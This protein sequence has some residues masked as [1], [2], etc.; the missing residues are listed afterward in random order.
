[1]NFKPLFNNVLIE[2]TEEKNI[3]KSGIIIPDNAKEKSSQGIV[4]AVGEGTINQS[5][6]RIKPSV[7]IGDKIMFAKWDGSEIKING[8]NFV[9]IKD[10]DIL[11]VLK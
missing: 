6:N 7:E 2:R 4:I 9:I 8:K 1:M 10:T 5:G 3:T 11:G